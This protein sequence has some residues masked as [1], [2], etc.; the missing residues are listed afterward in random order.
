MGPKIISFKNRLGRTQ[1]IN[2]LAVLATCTLGFIANTVYT[3]EKSADS[4]LAATAS[5]LTQ[6]LESALTFHDQAEVWK[7]L[8]SLEGHPSVRYS[9][10]YDF[11]GNEVASYP[12]NADSQTRTGKPYLYTIGS[13][14]DPQGTLALYRNGSI[15]E[16][17]WRG[18]VVV[19]LGVLVLGVLISKF[20]TF[21]NNRTLNY[22]FSYLIEAIQARRRSSNYEH[23]SVQSL[24][25]AK[26]E[27]I[28][29]FWEL[30]GEFDA[31][32]QSL[33]E[34]DMII[35]DIN[36]SL[37]KQV[38]E[39]TQELKEAQATLVQSSR[40]TALGELSANLSHEINNPLAIIAG[41]VANLR[42][43]LE[44]DQLL[45]PERQSYL[46]RIEATALRISK[47]I[48]GL[49][50]FSR[51]GSRDDFEEV[52]FEALFNDIL[53][54]CSNKVKQNSVQLKVDNPYPNLA[55]TCRATQIGQIIINLIN[56]AVDAIAQQEDR[57]V[58]LRV[59]E[60]ES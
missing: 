59:E 14:T 60:D 47:I 40:L 31:L 21:L 28:Q 10:V 48:R 33:K 25:E 2:T 24:A 22:Q 42:R 7:T 26:G 52:K 17:Y 49:K 38:E 9:V 39:R 11:Q 43:N 55:L 57:W 5:V 19:V 45:S 32:F 8:G 50:S 41:K 4:V 15:S 56:N 46:E 58:L 35:L 44:Q 6:S 53:E 27:R 16:D 37:E 51:D 13:K 36:N 12:K 3:S 23:A 30:A 1:L 34:R 54:V 20:L 29:E 18:T